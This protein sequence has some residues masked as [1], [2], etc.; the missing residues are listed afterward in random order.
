MRL[1]SGRRAGSTARAADQR[2]QS[3]GARRRNG[4]AERLRGRLVLC[5][6]FALLTDFDRDGARVDAFRT[7]STT[8][9][10]Q[11]SHGTFSNASSWRR[12]SVN[13]GSWCHPSQSRRLFHVPT[14]TRLSGLSA[15]RRSCPPIQPGRCVA[16][17]RRRRMMASQSRAA[18]S[19]RCA[20]VTIVII[21][22]SPPRTTP[23]YCV[24]LLSHPPEATPMAG[25]SARGPSRS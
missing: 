7:S 2:H 23:R 3:A 19:F 21:L 1:Y 20:C 6:T 18:P 8:S 10:H 11:C 25:S 4:Y 13:C 14:I 5:F 22:S 16:A 24:T 9:C 17:E 15:D 12:V